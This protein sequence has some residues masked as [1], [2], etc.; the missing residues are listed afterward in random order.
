[1]WL[2]RMKIKWRCNGFTN[3]EISDYFMN[4]KG[5]WIYLLSNALNF[6][7][8]KDN[9]LYIDIACMSLHKI[10]VIYAV[11]YISKKK[12][13]SNNLLKFL[14]YNVLSIYTLKH[15]KEIIK[16]EHFQQIH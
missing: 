4:N 15:S 13:Y 8:S 1:M 14:S 6:S 5:L 9:E 3:K 10:N 12:I 7:M 2:K 16:K 11:Q